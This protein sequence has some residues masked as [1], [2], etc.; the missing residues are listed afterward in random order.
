MQ[1]A[2]SPASEAYFLYAPTK[3]GERNDADGLHAAPGV[4]NRTFL[5]EAG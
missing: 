3:Q 5:S 4:R 2:R 1:G